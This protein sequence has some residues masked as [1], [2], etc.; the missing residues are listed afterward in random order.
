[1][2]VVYRH[3]WLMLGVYNLGIALFA[4]Y[5][6]RST[7]IAWQAQQPTPVFWPA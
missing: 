2:L 4:T 3:R 7:H 1:M 5:M 6:S